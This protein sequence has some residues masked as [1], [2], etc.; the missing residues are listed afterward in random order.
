[1]SLI[2]TETPQAL[3]QHF[4]SV[5]IVICTKIKYCRL[6]V[7]WTLYNMKNL[8]IV[9]GFYT[10]KTIDSSRLIRLLIQS[11]L[12]TLLCLAIIT[13]VTQRVK[14]LNLLKIHKW[15]LGNTPES[16][17]HSAHPARLHTS[18]HMKTCQSKHNQ[19]LVRSR[20]IWKICI[21]N[22]WTCESS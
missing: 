1:M 20:E 9:F 8:I 7:H 13:I 14:Y 19:M 16:L 18:I 21:R 11:S 6:C 15:R 3:V 10:H 4:L 5:S 2:D 12:L 22:N 17:C